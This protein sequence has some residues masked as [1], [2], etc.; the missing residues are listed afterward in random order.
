MKLLSLIL[1]ISYLTLISTSSLSNEVN[2]ENKRVREKFSELDCLAEL[3]DGKLVLSKFPEK[4]IDYGAEPSPDMLKGFNEPRY[5]YHHPSKAICV[6]YPPYLENNVK[7]FPK[8]ARVNHGN[9]LDVLESELLN[10]KKATKKSMVDFIGGELWIE[11]GDLKWINNESGFF[12]DILG[13]TSNTNF[14]KFIAGG[15]LDSLTDKSRVERTEEYKPSKGGIGQKIIYRA[16][17]KKK[18][19]KIK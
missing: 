2:A 17:K 6:F 15:M 10:A 4:V 18:L 8:G 7:G 11:N 14:N 9:I 5:V 12:F 3:K 1:L 19:R 13:S 16:D